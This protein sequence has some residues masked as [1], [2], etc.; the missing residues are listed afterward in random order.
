M[1]HNSASDPKNDRAIRN[2]PHRNEADPQR[3]SSNVEAERLMVALIRQGVQTI[4]FGRARIVAELLYRYVREQLRRHGSH[5]AEAVK[6]Y[7][8]GYLPAERRE[9]ERQLFSGELLGVTSTNALELGIDIGGLD[10]ALIVGFPGTVASTWQQAGRAG[11]GPEPALVIFIAYN[12]PVDQFIMRH[13]EYLLGQSP[14]SAVIDPENLYILAG[15][16]GCAAAEMPLRPEDARYFGARTGEVA[17]A[18]A[19]EGLLRA[20]GGAHYWAQ[21]HQPSHRVS[22]R[23]MSQDTYT[24]IETTA[25]SPVI[26]QVDAISAPELV[27]PEAVYLHEGQTYFVERLDLINKVAHVRREDTDYYTQAILESLI[28]VKGT[29]R[30][31]VWG[32][33]T[34]RFGEVDVTWATVAFKKIQFYSTDSLGWAKVD[35]PSQTLATTGVWLIPSATVMARV[36]AAGQNPSEGLIGIRNAAVHLLPLYAMCDKADIGGMIDSMNTGV[37]ALFLYDRYSGGLGFAETAY[38][39]LDELMQA[40]L[41]LIRECDCRDG[42]PSCVGVPILRPAIHADPD[43]GGGF[44]VPN[45]EAAVLMLQALLEEAG[46][47][48]VN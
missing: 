11:R 32:R 21:P 37:P 27:Y 13:P 20:A 41:Q 46:V 38:D 9:I 45:K 33:S 18:L 31:K 34:V 22:L 25:G 1:M 35:L 17:A 36:R 24:I 29:D 39:R 3:V 40:C 48:A 23:T 43:A 28:Q 15:H 47:L 5:L 7:R 42:C 26:G 6:P 10:A 2:P 8:G 30:E 12:E 44:P 16:L 19:D 14:E 4:A